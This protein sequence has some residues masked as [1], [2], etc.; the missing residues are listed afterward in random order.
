MVIRSLIKIAVAEN[1][2]YFFRSYKILYVLMTIM[3]EMNK[4]QNSFSDSV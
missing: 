4:D 3:S 2:M 1:K